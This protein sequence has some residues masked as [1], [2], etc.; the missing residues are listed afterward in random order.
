M[1]MTTV[2]VTLF[3]RLCSVRVVCPY[4]SLARASAA[5]AT[6]TGQRSE[7]ERNVAHDR[8]L[9]QKKK[10]RQIG[11]RPGPKFDR[12]LIECLHP[13]M[14]WV[15]RPGTKLSE[16]LEGQGPHKGRERSERVAG[17]I[18]GMCSR[19]HLGAVNS[20]RC[21]ASSLS[22]MNSEGDL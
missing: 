1:D 5:A 4:H 16:S 15:K 17:T 10:K 8:S 7:R 11:T 22:V 9:S 14:G 18:I 21:C 3:N 20:T 2:T 13:A 12:A 19:D 6:L